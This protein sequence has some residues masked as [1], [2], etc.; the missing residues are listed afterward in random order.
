[1]KRLKACLAFVGITVGMAA[2][3]GDQSSNAIIPT[4]AIRAGVQTR[5]AGCP[6]A[7]A[8]KTMIDNLFPPTTV[9]TATSDFENAIN[10]YKQGD[11][12]DA[13]ALAAQLYQFTMQQYNTGA[14]TGAGTPAG[15]QAVAAFTSAVFCNVG[16]NVTINPSLNDNVVAIVPA[17]TDAIVTTGTNMAGVHLFAAQRNPKS[18]VIIARLPNNAKSPGCPQDPGPVC[19]AAFQIPN[20]YYMT[21]LPKPQLSSTAPLFTAEVCLDPNVHVP[22]GQLFLAHNVTDNTAQV[23]PHATETLGL[24]CD[25]GTAMAPRRNLFELA[26]HGNIGGLASELA[27]RV[28]DFAVKDA[29]AYVGS[30]GGRTS[31]WSPFAAVDVDDIIPYQNGGWTYHAPTFSGT[32]APGTGDIPGVQ[33]T[34]ASYVP[35]NTWVANT[36]LLGNSPFGSGPQGFNCPLSG[37]SYLNTVWPSFTQPQPPPTND[38]QAASTI[39]L[40]RGTF[41]LPANW[42]TPLQ[43]GVA[44]DNDVEVF[45]NGTQLTPPAGASVSPQGF[46]TH[47]GC[48]AADAFVFNIPQNLLVTDGVNLNEIAIRARDRGGESYIDARVSPTTPF[49]P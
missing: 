47:E 36:S 42:T 12:N 44:V 2:C 25:G 49:G 10:Y 43:V 23:L 16:V 1:M 17:N 29:Y 13:Q 38:D 8:V 37:L 33:W 15:A 4:G 45:I 26:R 18:V 3:S 35:D 46:A 48:A 30:V 5:A 7:S 32:P 39:F 41:F 27:S 19:I 21:V 22:P 9:G 6:S 28:S 11:I 40:M 20:F 14:L 24:A 31:S 34:L